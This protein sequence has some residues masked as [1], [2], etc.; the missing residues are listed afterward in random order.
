M[1]KRVHDIN[2]TKH[3]YKRSNLNMIDDFCCS[4]T[5][6]KREKPKIC[7]YQRLKSTEL[8]LNV[9]YHLTAIPF[10]FK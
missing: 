3:L 6:S 2:T 7:P 10:S 5:I 8:Y 1:F 9:I 4:T